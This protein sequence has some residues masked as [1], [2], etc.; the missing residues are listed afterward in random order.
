MELHDDVRWGRILEELESVPEENIYP[1]GEGGWWRV[2]GY[3][4]YSE[5]NAAWKANIRTINDPATRWP[6]IHNQAIELV[7]EY[8][9]EARLLNN[10]V[11][12]NQFR[13][14]STE[15]AT[16]ELM[17]TTRNRILEMVKSATSVADLRKA[18]DRYGET[19]AYIYRHLYES[20]LATYFK[21]EA[22]NK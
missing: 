14:D 20:A 10:A 8:C 17:S 15:K 16:V 4:S 1:K 13:T 2:H 18:R 3:K 7:K 19:D 5:M 6:E 21:W 12:R 22:E 11:S 9:E